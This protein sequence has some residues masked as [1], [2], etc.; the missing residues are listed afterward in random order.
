MSFMMSLV[1]ARKR[2]D[3]HSPRLASRN[4]GRVRV[5]ENSDELLINKPAKHRMRAS[6]PGSRTLSNLRRGSIRVFSLLRNGKG[7]PSSS[8]LPYHV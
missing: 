5:T 6:L 2:K 1:P 3:F 8:H 7:M 4:K